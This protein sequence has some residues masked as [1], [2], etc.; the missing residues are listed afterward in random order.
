[1]VP[2]NN[3]T[4]AGEKKFNKSL[5]RCRSVVERTIGVLKSRWR[6]LDSSNTGGLQFTPE[7]SCQVI[8]ACI[9]LHNYCIRRRLP[10]N[11]LPH[12]LT[13]RDESV[14]HHDENENARVLLKKG[15]NQRNE[16]IRQFFGP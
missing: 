4:A 9:I 11:I 10:Y 16:I 3:P 7:V 1:M 2:F 8:G 14:R 12:I 5:K 13:D 15:K 6:C